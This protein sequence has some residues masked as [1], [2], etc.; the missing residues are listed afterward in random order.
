[1]AAERGGGALP[2]GARD[3]EDRL[4]DEAGSQLHLPDQLDLARAC[5]REDRDGERNA[6][7]D[8][9]Q[10]DP[11]Q[12]V[13]SHAP[14]LA[15]ERQLLV[16]RRHHLRAARPKQAGG[17]GAA[18]AQAHHEGV[19]SGEVHL[20]LSDASAVSARMMEMIQKRT[21]IF[22]SA[23]PCSSKWWWMGAMRKIRRPVRLNQNTCS[24]TETISA[25]KTP[26]MMALSTSFFVSTASAP[27]PPP[28]ASDPTSPMNTVA[29]YV[30]NQRKLMPA[31]AMAAHNTVSSA[32]PGMCG[33]SR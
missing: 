8:H 27:R 30:L 17:G 24:I 1:M 31:P 21:M 16:V 2:V 23:Q 13:G 10:I 7:A 19:S 5:L 22:G 20:S 28:R 9:H 14:Q 3:A 6:G 4:G 26:W 15:F 29:G 11:A 18:L 12:R 32:A 33:I 25:K